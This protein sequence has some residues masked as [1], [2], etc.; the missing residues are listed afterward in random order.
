LESEGLK[1]KMTSLKIRIRPGQLIRIGKL[2][3][4]IWERMQAV[5][6]I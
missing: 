3:R 1:A 4:L 2:N 6:K 5:E